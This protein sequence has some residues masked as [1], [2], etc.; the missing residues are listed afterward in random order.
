MQIT[1]YY[2][3]IACSLVPYVALTEAAADFEVKTVNFLK[4][5][6]MSP[7]FMSLNPKHKVPLLL[8]DGTPD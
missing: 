2:F 7:E 1:L 6:H 5:E 8:V 4:K 3:P